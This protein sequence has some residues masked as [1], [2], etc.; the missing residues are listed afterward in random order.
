MQDSEKGRWEMD[1]RR[2]SGWVGGGRATVLAEGEV[3]DG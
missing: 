1:K 2:D 3:G